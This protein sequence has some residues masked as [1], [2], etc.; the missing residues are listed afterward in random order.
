MGLQS[1]FPFIQA[2]PAPGASPS[3]PGGDGLDTDA[4]QA[5]ALDVMQTA[6]DWMR[7]EMLQPATLIQIGVIFAVLILGAMF[8]GVVRGWVAAGLEKLPENWRKLLLPTLPTLVR[9]ALWAAGMWIAQTALTG[10]G[11][12][13]AFVRIAT[14]LATAWLIIRTATS[15]IPSEYR[16]PVSWFA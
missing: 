13:V 9:S 1:F 16:K 15:F 2:D 6:L 14:S 7:E 3:A 10:A 11:Q 5:H 8:A 12:P 4:L